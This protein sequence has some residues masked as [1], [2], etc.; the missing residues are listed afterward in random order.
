MKKPHWHLRRHK[1]TAHTKTKNKLL[2][3]TVEGCYQEVSSRTS[4]LRHIKRIHETQKEHVCEE[5]NAQFTKKHQLRSHLY[6][7][8][9]V[10][11]FS[12]EYCTSKFV[13]ITDYKKHKR[14]HKS[15]TC[16]CGEVFYRWTIFRKHMREKC[17]KKV[18]TCSTCEKSFTHKPHYSMHL[19]MHNES[20]E[21]FE[22]P[23]EYC[24][25]LYYYKRNLRQHIKSFHMKIKPKN[26]RKRKPLPPKEKRTVR[27][28]RKDAGTTKKSSALKLTGLNVPYEAEKSIIAGDEIEAENISDFIDSSDFS[29]VELRIS[30]ISSNKQFETKNQTIDLEEDSVSTS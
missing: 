15:Y 4:L 18:Y 26:P 11:P 6:E 20:R 23:Y 24:E 13:T 1:K 22:C 29:D 17:G 21:V 10:A 27:A 3:C 14:S 19:L 2:R 25:R 30:I 7:H 5:C 12:C 8:T 28:R 9:G 16:K